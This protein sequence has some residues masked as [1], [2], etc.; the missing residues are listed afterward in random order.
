M[1]IRAYTHFGSFYGPTVDG[2]QMIHQSCYLVDIA[3][4]PVVNPKDSVEGL[5]WIDRDYARKGVK[6]VPQLEKQ[7]IP[8]LVERGYV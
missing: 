1:R 2:K 5:E 6:L 3:G 7:I 4:E 8:E